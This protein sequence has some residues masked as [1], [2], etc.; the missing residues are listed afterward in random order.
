MRLTC[1]FW[2]WC[3]SWI[4]TIKVNCRLM[5]LASIN[6]INIVPTPYFLVHQAYSSRFWFYS[7]WLA[8]STISHAERYRTE[9]DALR[10]LSLSRSTKLAF[11]SCQTLS[12]KSFCVNDRAALN[13]AH[14]WR[15]W[16]SLSETFRF[17][18][19]IPMIF[20]C[21]FTFTCLRWLS[22]SLKM[23][24]ARSIDC[25]IK[26]FYDWKMNKLS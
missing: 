12:S 21:T 16:V 23:F 4:E 24:F 19:P 2:L 18:A 5:S 10:L 26:F 1:L 11:F 7:I 9:R 14:S 25:I 8:N 13:I 6:A 3:V 15:I 17:T 20:I 22:C